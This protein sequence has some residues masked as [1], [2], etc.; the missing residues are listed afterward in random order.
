MLMPQAEGI[1]GTT[2]ICFSADFS[3]TDDPVLFIKGDQLTI[4]NWSSH[5]CCFGT[6]ANICVSLDGRPTTDEARR[7]PNA[8]S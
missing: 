4:D 1:H 7:R 5:A 8:Q 3:M 6:D 2:R